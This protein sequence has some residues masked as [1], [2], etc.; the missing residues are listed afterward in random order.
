[1]R[2]ASI[3]LNVGLWACVLTS[4]SVGQLTPTAGDASF[5]STAKLTGIE[6]IDAA[7]NTVSNRLLVGGSG[8]L[9]DRSGVVGVAP[10]FAVPEPSTWAL[11]LGMFGMLGACGLY[12]SATRRRRSAA[13]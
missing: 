11:M 13:L 4:S 5:M 1:M 9:Y 12:R 2:R 7:G 6:V 8:T 3:R 10:P